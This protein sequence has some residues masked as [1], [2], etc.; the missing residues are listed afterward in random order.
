M[1]GVTNRELRELAEHRLQSIAIG[2]PLDALERCL[3]RV[4]LAASVTS[5]NRPAI[6]EAVIEAFDAG[7]SA[8]QI[9]EVVSLVS[10]LGVHSLITTATV[11]ADAAKARGDPL[12]AELSDRQQQLWQKYVGDDSYWQAFELA[13]PGF[14]DALVRLSTDQFEAFFIFCAVPWRDGHVR[15]RTKEL[16]AIACDATPAHRF[17]PGFLLHLENA[18]AI[19]VGR[20]AI[21][22]AL[23][24]AANAP[25]HVGIR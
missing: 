8:V 6:E 18:I 21:F 20:R 22:E 24:L 11:I 1:P 3:I 4:A 2:E 19:G 14:L 25:P 12:K 9:Q 17:L 7:A 23:D 13:V 15:A 5:L 10:G 16:A